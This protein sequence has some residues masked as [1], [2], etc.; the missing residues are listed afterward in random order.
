MMIGRL[1]LADT[2]SAGDLH[3]EPLLFFVINSPSTRGYPE[4]WKQLGVSPEL[5]VYCARSLGNKESRKKDY[6][7]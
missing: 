2:P 3:K 4:S 1:G 7:N 5:S 6:K